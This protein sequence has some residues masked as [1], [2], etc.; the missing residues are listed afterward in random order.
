M[1][2]WWNHC[3]QWCRF[4]VSI[5]RLTFPT[6]I[7]WIISVESQRV[8]R[9]WY[10]LA[11]AVASRLTCCTLNCTSDIAKTR[12]LIKATQTFVTF[13]DTYYRVFRD[14]ALEMEASKCRLGSVPFRLVFLQQLLTSMMEDHLQVFVCHTSL[15][16][17]QAFSMSNNLL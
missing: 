16:P 3:I 6:G 13:D 11:L 9:E 12:L 17:L 15:W 8:S 1:N 4:A 10:H 2:S 7:C 14:L 5:N